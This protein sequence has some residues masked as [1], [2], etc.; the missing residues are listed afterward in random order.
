MIPQGLVWKF[1]RWDNEYHRRVLTHEELYFSS[2]SANHKEDPE[3]GFSDYVQDLSGEDLIELLR[4]QKITVDIPP[5]ILKDGLPPEEIVKK[6]VRIFDPD[7]L[8]NLRDTAFQIADS[9]HGILSLTSSIDSKEVWDHHAGGGAG[10]AVGYEPGH[11][12]TTLGI[13]GNNVHYETVRRPRP[14]LK[15]SEM[16]CLRN[17]E[18]MMKKI[19]TIKY[20]WKKNGFRWE[21]EYRCIL[22][23]DTPLEEHQRQ[24]WLPGGIKTIVLGPEI[25]E[26]TRLHIMYTIDLENIKCPVY[27]TEWQKDQLYARQIRGGINCT[28]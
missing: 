14:K 9:T 10:F 4:Q 27:A 24:R 19:M 16:L 1:R 2:F 8:E 7:F 25:G 3:E 12:C 11:L 5:Q 13:I 15:I 23:S 28:R 26:W 6:Y 20:L 18:E 21:K 22:V 17:D